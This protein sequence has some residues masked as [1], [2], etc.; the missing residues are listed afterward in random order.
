MERKVR[1]EDEEWTEDGADDD[2]RTGKESV[3]SVS[4]LIPLP[5]LSP[6]SGNGDKGDDSEWKRGRWMWK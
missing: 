2:T 3:S 4:S 1:E 5:T 6:L